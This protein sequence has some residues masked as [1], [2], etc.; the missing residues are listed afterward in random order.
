LFFVSLFFSRPPFF[1]TVHTTIS[2]PLGCLAGLCRRLSGAKDFVGL[3][4][5]GA[6]FPP[7][8]PVWW[9]L[10]TQKPDSNPIAAGKH[11]A[12]MVKED[13]GHGDRVAADAPFRVV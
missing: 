10:A 11:K 9:Q 12:A 2:F 4:K 6:C 13:E 3:G 5:R 1:F 8:V 7:S